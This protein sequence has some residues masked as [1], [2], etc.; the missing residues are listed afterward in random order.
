MYMRTV[1][2][3][4][5]KYAQLCHNYYDPQKGRS[6]T[7]VL[8]SF[9][10]EDNL[11]LDALR[12]L[13]GSICRYLDP[14]EAD[15]I[16]KEAGIEA[17]Q[18][19]GS[20]KLGGAWL[21]DG[22]WKRIGIDRVL[23][24]MLRSRGYSTPVERL[25]FSMVANRAL[26]PLS[27]LAMEDWVSKEVM[28]DGLSEVEV[29]QLYRCMD[30]LLEA[31][32]DIQLKVYQAVVNLF[33]MELDLVFIDTTTAYFEIQG[34]GDEGFRK[35]GYNK[36]NHPEL[37]QV[38]IGFA[39]TRDGIPIRCWVWPGNTSDK[40]VIDEVKKD[41]NGWKLGRVIM[42]M[43]TG[44]NSEK[45]RRILQGA[46]DHYI[47]GEKMRLGPD[48]KPP[49]ALQRPGKYQKLDN[50]LEVKE[51]VVGGDSEAR[52]RFVIVL[53][54][55]EQEH[56][57]KKRD[58]I[59][60]EVERKLEELKQLEGEPHTKAACRLRSHSAYGKYI[61]QTK[62]GKLCLDRA[63]IKA[64]S[65]LD[66]KFLVSTSD[67]WLSA[68][69]VALGYKHLWKIER[70]NRDLKNVVD[71]RPVYHRIEDRIRA[72][73]LLCWLALVLI[74][75]AENESLKNW[76]EIKNTL[77]NLEVGIH[78]TGNGKVWQRTPIDALQKDLFSALGIKPP[79][80]F[81]NIATPQRKKRQ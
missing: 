69:D 12:R 18:F 47:I 73:V 22:L 39:M 57:R 35:W 8:F 15:S 36:D 17:F 81:P 80:Q 1:T 28:I 27:K 13:V 33:N 60:S 76:H 24:K 20:R 46:G 41:L 30:F 70:L 59:L 65:H 74:R 67:D 55:V 31:E 42:V 54:P 10:R 4:G 37:A 66:G 48:G 56:D 43:D 7:R 26:E 6:T 34:E 78:Q 68:E 9:G 25:L 75:V 79:P 14:E 52:R 71:V 49:L 51:V 23:K 45:N 72:H 64:E 62:R 21:L 5:T 11:D 16:R 3:K 19:L 50:G 58:D 63:R 44:F 32:K 38:V 77:C 2:T 40:S 29:H 61:R 53:N